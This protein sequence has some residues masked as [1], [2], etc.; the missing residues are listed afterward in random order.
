MSSWNKH[1]HWKTKNAT[2]WTKEYFT[3]NLVG[4]TH[5]LTKP[6]KG[7]VK[8]DSISHFEG[9]VELG[10]RKGR[11]ITIYDCQLTLDWSG[12]L[13]DGKSEEGTEAKGTISF[14]EVSHEVQD[15]GEEYKY[16]VEMTSATSVATQSMLEAVRSHLA[17]SLLPYFHKFR[18]ELV[19][20][21]A[22]DVG[23]EGSNEGT[24]TGGSGVSTP[25]DTSAAQTSS[26]TAATST[27]TSS[28][29]KKEESSKLS[30]TKVDVESDLS[31]RSDDL[32]DLLTN[33]GR[34]PMW[35][36]APAQLTL[37]PGSTFSLFN[38][39]VTGSIISI[40]P[41]NKLVQKWRAPQWPPNHFGTLTTTLAQ[42]ESSTKL[43]LTLEGVPLEEEDRSRDALDRFYIAGLKGL[44][45]GTGS[46]M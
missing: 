34:I 2:P 13:E 33:P 28:A 18:D 10:N 17:P 36:R 19:A 8:I 3:K 6:Q 44:G 23:H 7:N 5:E 42:G 12:R 21:H 46:V 43:T 29:P 30:T 26:N 20:T 37:N 4:A 11:L 40:E 35:T 27:S 38:G 16:R 9:D 1:Y 25:K 14:P 45:L 15:E 39:N 22:K 32:W 41:T 24:P 31:I